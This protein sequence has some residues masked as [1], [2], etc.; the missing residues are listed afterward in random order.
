MLVAII[1]SKSTAVMATRVNR[2]FITE[3][4]PVSDLLVIVHSAYLGSGKAPRKR[5][6]ATGIRPI[7][8]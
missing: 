6:D 1:T 4:N 3:E 2:V 8:R 5:E 7:S